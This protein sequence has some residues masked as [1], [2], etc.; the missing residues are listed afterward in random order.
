[1]RPR[2]S[3]VRLVR[4]ANAVDT[5]DVAG[6]RGVVRRTGVIRLVLAVAALALVLAAAASA[7]DPETSEQTLVPPDRL[8][9]VVLDLSLSI[10]DDDYTTIRRALRRLV[11]E[12]A[13]IGLAVF[14]DAP[15]EL[16]PPG[17]SA[18]EL[19]PIL[20]LLVPPRLGP[21]RN[22]W[23]QT[24]RAGTRISSAL[25]LAKSMLERDRV[26]KGSILLV[27]DLETAPDDV[28][29]LARTID[30]IGRVGIKLRV[31]PLAPSSDAVALFSGLLG[32]D[33]VAALTR[34]P[35]SND[36]ESSAARVETPVLFLI[37]GLL[38][39]L[40]LAAHERFAGRIALPR[41]ERLS[42]EPT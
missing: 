29:A 17:T 30:E 11:A 25:D 42:G 13:S 36:S 26:A 40:T 32:Q 35:R 7:R 28:P 2:E 41:R 39:F 27:S 38:V 24:F 12:N 15:Y 5:H 9:V 18:K 3:I 8:G 21:V 37:L 20:R 22:P 31:V 33:A 4:P 6:L 16:F 14:S 10:T 23:T 19:Q 34:T 1:V